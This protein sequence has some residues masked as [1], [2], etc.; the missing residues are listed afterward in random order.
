MKIYYRFYCYCTFSRFLNHSA[1][2]HE[3]ICEMVSALADVSWQRTRTLMLSGNNAKQWV[4][5]HK[6]IVTQEFTVC[7]E[8]APNTSVTSRAKELFPYSAPFR[9]FLSRCPPPVS[10]CRSPF[11][12]YHCVLSALPRVAT[13]AHENPR[14]KVAVFPETGASANVSG[15]VSMQFQRRFCNLSSRKVIFNSE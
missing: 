4:G 13:G 10:L 5:H 7:Y 11:F 8:K 15:G 12:R 2:T 9:L 14:N 6:I 1:R 3:H